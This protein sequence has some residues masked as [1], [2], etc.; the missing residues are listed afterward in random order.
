MK[1][2]TWLIW[3]V[4]ISG[5]AAVWWLVEW[6]ANS[7]VERDNLRRAQFTACVKAAGGGETTCMEKLGRPAWYPA[8]ERACA[9]IGAR[10]ETVLRLDGLPKWQDLFKNERC[11]RLGLPGSETA[12]ADGARRQVSSRWESCFTDKSRPYFCAEQ[13][14]RHVWHPVNGDHCSDMTGWIARDRRDGDP[15]PWDYL[16]YNERCWRLDFRQIRLAPLE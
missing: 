16:F 15:I 4:S 5:A 14:G 11:A 7:A 13:L 10:I 6:A 9:A 8:D 1:R 3:L 12:A 2:R